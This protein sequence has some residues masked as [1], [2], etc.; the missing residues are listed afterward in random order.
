MKQWIA[1]IA[2]IALATGADA[3]QGHEP[4]A[5]DAGG[6]HFEA[7]NAG[8]AGIVNVTDGQS[9]AK[10]W[11]V[12]VYRSP[13]KNKALEEDVQW[14]FI[15]ALAIDDKD[16]VVTDEHARRFA[17]DLKTHHVRALPKRP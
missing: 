5:I 4:V 16:L 1:F 12:V 10:Q 11:S 14:I 13:I 3:K 2:K 17:V 9:H 8:A 7:P 6:L 15:V